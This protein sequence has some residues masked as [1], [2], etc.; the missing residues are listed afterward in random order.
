[1]FSTMQHVNK[2]NPL[3]T[4]AVNSDKHVLQAHLGCTLDFITTSIHV[5]FKI[6]VNF[7]FRSPNETAILINIHCLYT[8]TSDLHIYE[9]SE[10]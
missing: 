10:T 9:Q 3:Q 7:I 8:L 1:M 2:K 6:Q 4:A 5:Q